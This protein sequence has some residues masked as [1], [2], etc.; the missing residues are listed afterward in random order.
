MQTV[1]EILQKTTTYFE[2]KGVPEARLQAQRL[3]GHV[4]E[5]GRLE[6]YLQFERPMT[7]EALDKL[8]PLVAR[9]AKR[10]PLQHIL[11][12]TDFLEL[13]LKCDARALIPR[14]ETE[15]LAELLTIHF[16]PPPPAVLDLGTG[17]GALAL[18]LA[19]VWPDSTITAVDASPDALLLAQ[20]NA[21]LNNL[22]GRVT[23]LES[24]WF[25]AV[26]G[27]RF[28][29]IVSNPPYLTEEEMTT[30][31]PEVTDFEPT[32]A[33]VSGP[34]GLN[35]LRKIIAEAPGFLTSG[36]LLALETGIAQHATLTTLAAEAGFRKSEAK[37]DISGRP[38][39]FWAWL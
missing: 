31:A 20:E 30:A 6:L 7:S 33:L 11:G 19:S 37:R 4:L 23:F 14:P 8:R 38:R 34:D 1:L 32:R 5:C 16:A 35:D 3:M 22:S 36:G 29:L 21:A 39:F 12:D 15:E 9:R 27:Q 25:L 26:E 2:Q 17:T 28:D 10:E 13:T 18:G 24:D